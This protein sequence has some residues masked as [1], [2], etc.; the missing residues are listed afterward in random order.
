M[1]AH[2]LS[3]SVPDSDSV[4]GMAEQTH[5]DFSWLTSMPPADQVRLLEDPSQ[6]LSDVMNHR[7]DHSPGLWW[8][9]KV[10]GGH[11]LSVDAV[12]SL[13]ALRAQL[14]FWWENY[15]SD[16]DRAYIT[17]RRNDD[18]DGSYAEKVKA[19]NETESGDSP[20]KRFVLVR[21]T[22]TGTFRLPSEIQAY[23]EV[24]LRG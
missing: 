17:K 6:P 10:P 22:T 20:P 1:A 11:L 12:A 5:Q 14:D 21:D 19:A 23:V 13:A 3:V 18:L 9:I 15:L 16:A 7:L 2:F 8:S 24:V 4:G